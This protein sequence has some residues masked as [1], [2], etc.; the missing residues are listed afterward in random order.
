[1]QILAVHPRES[2]LAVFEK[3]PPLGMLWI[4]NVLRRAG[5]GLEFLDQQ[6]D[7]RDPACLAETTRPHLALIG[8]T[9]HSRFASFESARRI[10]QASPETV[11]IYGGP[12][13]TFT[14]E[15][16]LR[17]VPEIDI[18]VHGEGEEPSLELA[19]WALR[20]QGRW[21]DLAR[22]KGISY[23]EAGG[24]MRTPPRPPIRDLDTLGR[25]ARDLVPMDRYRMMMDYLDIPGTSLITARGCPIMC[26]YCSASAMFG[27]SY[28]MRSP[29]LV[30]DEVEDLLTSTG[31]Q[32]IKVFDSTFTLNREHVEDFCSELKR[33]GIQ[34]P[35]ECEIRVGSVSKRLLATMQEAGCYYV[36][37]GVE[38]GVQR[39]LD[40]CVRKKISL[41]KAEEFLRWT[42]EL[43]LLTKVFFT[44]GHPG[45]TFGEALETNR[46]IWRNRRK[47][48]LSAYQAG[49]KIYPGTYVA[50]FARENGLMPDGFRWSAPYENLVNRKLLRPVDNVPLLMQPGLGLKELRRLRLSFIAMR[51]FSLRFVFEK[52]RAILRARTLENYVRIIVRGVRRGSG[53]PD[54]K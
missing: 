20:G 33:R 9:T 15:D 1:M 40:E 49:I 25:P 14:A 19:D 54:P 8:G 46:F 38:S 52:M 4:A 41:P 13:A 3:M 43:G 50:Q 11:V 45:E 23:R 48:R 29:K 36:D 34:V 42:G 35:W 44:V 24:I 28:R 18:V 7:D 32:G 6:V 22:I 51:V 37:V 39:V 30:V 26:T 12:H 10:K 16:T 27:R 31:A 2:A 47:I 17:H 21:Q 5:Y 53:M